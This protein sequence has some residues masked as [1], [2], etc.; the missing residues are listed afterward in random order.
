M[1]LDLGRHSFAE[2]AVRGVVLDAGREARGGIAVDFSD[3]VKKPGDPLPRG[4]HLASCSGADGRFAF[5]L[6]RN[7]RTDVVGRISARSEEAEAH[8]EGVRPG[9]AVE[10]ILQTIDPQADVVFE[11]PSS[12][13]MRLCIH[14]ED[15][16]LAF[17]RGGGRAPAGGIVEERRRLPPESTWSRSF[18]G[19]RLPVTNGPVSTSRSRD[20]RPQR[21][22]IEPAFAPARTVT[23]RAR[24]G[25]T[26][27]WV[28]RIADGSTFVRD[29]ATPDAEGRFALRGVPTAEILFVPA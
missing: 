9:E 25:T 3:E 28:T 10:L 27:A 21:V 18:A 12:P 1:P 2:A 24:E 17:M 19:S 14:A 22:R 23:G 16:K 15:R 11:V 4:V 20:V 6:A 29:S 7:D 5:S 8:R 26:V 13:E